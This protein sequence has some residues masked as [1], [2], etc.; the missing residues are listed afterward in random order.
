MVG[1]ADRL[2]DVDHRRVVVCGLSDYFCGGP[3]SALLNLIYCW[4][5]DLLLKVRDLLL[6]SWDSLLSPADALLASLGTGGLTAP[7][8]PNEY[9]WVLGVTGMSQAVAIVA[10][11]MLVRVTLQSIPFVP[12]GS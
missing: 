4:C 8:I 3:M 12:G 9:A 7:I 5:V 2:A 6:D 1:R 11:A 10:G